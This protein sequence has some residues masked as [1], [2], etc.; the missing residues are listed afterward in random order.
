MVTFILCFFLPGNAALQRESNKSFENS[1][2]RNTLNEEKI[3]CFSCECEWVSAKCQQ[4]SY[5]RFSVCIQ[6]FVD[7]CFYVF[8]WEK[9]SNVMMMMMA[10]TLVSLSAELIVCWLLAHWGSATRV[11]HRNTS[12]IRIS[13]AAEANVYSTLQ[14]R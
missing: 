11:Y 9:V 6:S 5:V 12:V 10:S 14:L 3:S 13:L 7:T 2:K 4:T 1:Y 8:H